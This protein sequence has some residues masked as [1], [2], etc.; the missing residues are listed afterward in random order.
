MLLG[1]NSQACEILDG[2]RIIGATIT[3]QS[4]SYCIEDVFLYKNGASLEYLIQG[5]ATS[6][7]S[8]KLFV[9]KH[10]RLSGGTITL[11]TRY[12]NLVGVNSSGECIL[13]N[14]TNKSICRNNEG[15]NTPLQIKSNESIAKL[16][17]SNGFWI[18]LC[19][20][21]PFVQ[22]NPIP[23]LYSS[24]LTEIEAGNIIL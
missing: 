9:I 18:F 11:A 6:D 23:V 2:T 16:N 10:E 20:E 4:S 15:L 12:F 1:E 5:Y 8:A 24:A 22:D 14:S 17:Y 19:P 13:V 7:E 3:A 21:I